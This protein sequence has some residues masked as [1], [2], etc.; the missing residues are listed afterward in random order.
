MRSGRQALEQVALERGPRGARPVPG[1]LAH[2]L[3]HGEM[4]ALV[5]DVPIAR[6]VL[7]VP[8]VLVVAVGVRLGQCDAFSLI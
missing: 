1:K 5:A 8:L 3:D 7:A 4:V 6:I 2:S